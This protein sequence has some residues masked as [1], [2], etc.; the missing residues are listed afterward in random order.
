MAH[1]KLLTYPYFLPSHVRNLSIKHIVFRLE[2][3][4]THVLE[5][6]VLFQLRLE[7]PRLAVPG[8]AV[9]SSVAV[10]LSFIIC[11]AFKFTEYE[12]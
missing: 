9:V 2:T 10:S 5:G 11:S 7:R 8:S 12:L 6:A 4:S 1:L 3:P